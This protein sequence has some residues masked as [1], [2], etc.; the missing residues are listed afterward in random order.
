MIQKAYFGSMRGWIIES[1]RDIT[2]PPI[3]LLN[4]K[5]HQVKVCMPDFICNALEKS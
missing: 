4:N 2:K 1:Q 5:G 3:E